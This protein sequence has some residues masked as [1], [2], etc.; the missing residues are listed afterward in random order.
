M[1]QSPAFSFST[2]SLVAANVAAAVSLVLLNK[3]LLRTWPFALALTAAHAIFTQ[4]ATQVMR[5]AGLLDD[6]ASLPAG[7]VAQ[8]ALCGVLSVVLM[9][10]SL[11]LN[12]IGVFQAS[13]MLV[14][15]A[16]VIVERA[17]RG[18]AVRGDVAR[19]LAVILFGVALSAPPAAFS[20]LKSDAVSPLGLAVALAAIFVTASAVILIGATQKQLAATP[21]ALLDAQ[22]RYIILYAIAMASSFENTGVM[23]HAVVESS[24]TALLVCASSLVAVM[25]N[26]TGFSVISLLS[27]LSYQVVSQF[28]TVATLLLSVLLLGETMNAR[29]AAGF[30]VSILGIAAYSHA[31][32]SP[33]SD[34]A[35][36]ATSSDFAC[37]LPLLYTS[38]Q[39]AAAASCAPASV[40][41][42]G[43]VGL[44]VSAGNLFRN[45][46]GGISSHSAVL[47][48]HLLD[49][50]GT[51]TFEACNV[52]TE[53]PFACVRWDV[54]ACAQAR[55]EAHLLRKWIL[56]NHAAG[57]QHFIIMD[58][59][60]ARPDGE[61]DDFY[62]V[63]AQFDRGLVTTLRFPRDVVNNPSLAEQYGLR[64]KDFLGLEG[65]NAL[66]KRCYDMYRIQAR[67][68]AFMNVTEIFVPH[69]NQLLPA[70][71]LSQPHV[72]S[73]E[74]IRSVDSVSCVSNLSTQTSTT[75]TL[76]EYVPCEPG[77]HRLTTI[78]RG[79]T[80]TFAREEIKSH[81]LPTVSS[82]I[83]HLLSMGCAASCQTV[84]YF[85]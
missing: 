63:I 39:D 81:Q 55:M 64:R 8:M 36:I 42:L 56:S 10:V 80:K 31:R 72:L 52:T 27:P 68:I 16:T 82:N 70:S 37:S 74:S 9:N 77:M 2:V 54:I 7:P 83:R 48:P 45:E 6:A 73:N 51:F 18:T 43:L 35:V 59:N 17:V 85:E 13:K 4:A 47:S 29:Q 40:L 84:P 34:D 32:M 58:N 49:S 33:G 78:A 20:S 25:L 75:S 69:E 41:A 44:I 38:G 14:V 71:Y 12:S 46:R 76:A 28:K 53:A 1:S 67:W 66:M 22:Q 61:H 50:N 5:F 24:S 60:D 21:L 30:A 62:S 65:D 23:A 79:A 19:A 3:V 11:S 26:T 57:I 15:P